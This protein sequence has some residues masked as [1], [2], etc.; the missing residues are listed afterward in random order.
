[1]FNRFPRQGIWTLVI[2]SLSLS[3]VALES[4]KG[5]AP[6]HISASHTEGKGLGYSK[7][8]SS[9]DLFL[10]QPFR[11]KTVV[12][13]MDLRGH[14]FN[15]GKYA[16]NAGLGLRWL[17]RCYRQVWGVNWF[18]DYLQTSHRP[19]NQVSMGLEALGEVWEGRI[20]GYLP[21][22]QKRTPL[23]AFNYESLL[24]FL[25]IG[26]EQF[27]MKGIDSEVGYHFCRT[28]Y[29]DL[30]TGLGPY[31]YWGSSAATE[32]AFRR[33]HKHAVGGRLSAR[34][35]FMQYVTLEGVTTYDN[36][37]KWTG[38]GTIALTLPFNFT[39]RFKNP[40]KDRPRCEN[41][42]CLR[43]KLY[44][45]VLRNEIIV[46][47]KIHRYSTNPDILDPEFEP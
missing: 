27:A 37:F 38:Q 10:S 35:S 16:A 11:Q 15:D 32:N 14:I 24:P 4:S 7:G 2:C 17:N 12:P 41:S 29:F 25:V 28:K 22:G 39:F 21:V 23:L 36:R 8:Y 9:L 5:P 44:Q 43:E 13:F 26:K 3:C 45:M 18:Y 47:D 30:Y 34:L 31:Y 19:Y 20:N 33:A 46:I 1:M 42:Y 6:E 40:E